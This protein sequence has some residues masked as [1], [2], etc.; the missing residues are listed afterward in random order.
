MFANLGHPPK[1]TKINGCGLKPLE[2]EMHSV[3]SY[4]IFLMPIAYYSMALQSIPL[5]HVAYFFV[6]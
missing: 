5:L 2:K 6:C 4:F 3:I 1:C